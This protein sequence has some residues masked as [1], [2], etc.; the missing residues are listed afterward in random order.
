M[1]SLVGGK[2]NVKIFVLY[3][4]QNINYPM[5]YITVNDIVMQN[6][7]VL[8]LD[9]AE[10][11]HEML[12]AGLIE[13]FAQNEHGDDLYV[14]TSKGRLI[15]QELHGEIHMALLQKSLSCALRY[16]DFR[17]RGITIS[18]KIEKREDGRYDVIC[19]VNEKNSPIL[20]TT[21]AVDNLKFAQKMED[22]FRDH[23]EIVYRGIY[24]LVAGNINFLFE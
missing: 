19:T 8:Y 6:D 3:L 21:L 12:D 9:F 22:N 7:Y 17:K 23:P 5:D 14:V 2:Q 24:S 16:L 15:A 11:F 1:G 10:S 20:T 4:M 18:C 13:V